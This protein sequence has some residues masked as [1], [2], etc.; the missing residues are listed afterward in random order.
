MDY[1]VLKYANRASLHHFCELIDRG[2]IEGHFKFMI[3]QLVN[4]VEEVHIVCLIL[5]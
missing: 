2:K 4:I 1:T 3:M 5:V